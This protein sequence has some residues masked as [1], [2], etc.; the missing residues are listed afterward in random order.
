MVAVAPGQLQ[1]LEDQNC[2]AFAAD[3]AVRAVREGL[4]ATVLAEHTRFIEADMALGRRN[5]I[6]ACHDGDIAKAC[7]YRR[8]GPMNGH[9]RARAGGFHR[10]AGTVQ[11][12]QK[13]ETVRTQRRYYGP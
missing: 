10:F 5:R 2:D 13:A 12:Q 8:Q 1:S 4:A 6:D 9:K 7:L 3:V 11:V